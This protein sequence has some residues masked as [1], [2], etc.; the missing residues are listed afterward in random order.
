MITIALLES[1]TFVA[2]HGWLNPPSVVMPRVD[3]WV[4][5]GSDKVIVQPMN[6]TSTLH[7][8]SA[9]Y[10]CDSAIIGWGH[11]KTVGLLI[12]KPC[13][14]MYESSGGSVPMIITNA[15]VVEQQTGDYSFGT[16]KYSYR[17]TY[18]IS[19][20][21]SGDAE[22]TGQNSN[23]PTTP[24]STVPAGGIPPNVPAIQLGIPPN[25]NNI[26]F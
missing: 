14:F 8:S 17:V 25:L 24:A 20:V 21:C 1:T 10:L 6:Y 26:G 2:F 19:H 5:Y 11:M 9:V 23:N 3:T 4:P 15:D 13:N 7:T 22:M 12:G 18:S 16:T